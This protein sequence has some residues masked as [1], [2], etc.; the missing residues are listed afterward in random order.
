VALAAGTDAP[1]GPA[2]PWLA[3]QAAV[4]RRTRAGAL[5]GES[6]AVTPERALALFTTPPHA[7]GGPPRSVVAGAPADLCLLALPWSR[8]RDRLAAADV[9]GTWVAGRRIHGGADG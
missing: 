2:D 6:E 8:A 5:L 3:M 9:V 4:D 7:P 1:Y